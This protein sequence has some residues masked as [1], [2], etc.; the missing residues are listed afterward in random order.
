MNS[1]HHQ[2]I[3]RLGAGLTVTAQAAD[4]LIEGVEDRSRAFCV[5]TQ[6]HPEA[7]EAGC[8]RLIDALVSAAAEHTEHGPAAL[9]SAA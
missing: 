8:Q 6:W 3:D 9:R 7:E 4:G 2:A 5:G 1:Y